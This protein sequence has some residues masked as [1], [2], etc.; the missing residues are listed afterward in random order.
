M[1]AIAANTTMAP[2]ASAGNASFH[3]SG[4]G[5]GAGV[6]AGVGGTGV[7]SGGSGHS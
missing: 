4:P 7:G 1:R 3:W 5:L 2:I 6:G